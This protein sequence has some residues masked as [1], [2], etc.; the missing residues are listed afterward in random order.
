[1]KDLKPYIDES[2]FSTQGDSE[3]AASVEDEIKQEKISKWLEDCGI[4]RTDE[5]VIVRDNQTHIIYKN[6]DLLKFGFHEINTKNMKTNL[7][8]LNIRSISLLSSP[9]GRLNHLASHL[10]FTISDNYIQKISDLFHKDFELNG[11]GSISLNINQCLKLK[12][13]QGCPQKVDYLYILNTPKLSS[14]DG[15]PSRID[16]R[17]EFEIDT[18]YYTIDVF[19][20]PNRAKKMAQTYKERLKTLHDQKTI[21]EHIKKLED[22]YNHIDKNCPIFENFKIIFNVVKSLRKS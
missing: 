10:N 21:E 9:N 11:I 22:Y 2:L 16:T 18:L 6:E 8:P 19:Y 7:Y 17:F 20:S 1:M 5:K 13:L 4:K 3:G 15:M 14:L 12:D